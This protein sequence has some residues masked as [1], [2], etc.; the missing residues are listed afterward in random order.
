[1]NQPNNQSTKESAPLDFGSASVEL[2]RGETDAVIKIRGRFTF[3]VQQQFR[4]VMDALSADEDH[5]SIV[6]DMGAVAYLDSAALGM[7]YMLKEKVGATRKL[8]ITRAN[9][10]VLRILHAAYVHK[11]IEIPQLA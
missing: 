9:P 10:T 1:M 7:I 5:H 8:R 6:I 2:I 4:A 11:V 3:L